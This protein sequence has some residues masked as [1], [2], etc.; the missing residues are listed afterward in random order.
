MVG[1]GHKP[2]VARRAVAEAVVAMAPETAARIGQGAVPNGDV[3]AVARIARIMGPK[4]RSELTPLGHP[5]PLDRGGVEVTRDRGD[6]RVRVRA[7]AETPARTGVEMEA[8][9]AAS[10]A[11]LAVY[12]MV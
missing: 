9:T 5:L 4:R 8:L 7:E 1:V 11:A 6:G 2:V 12:D 3:E 10:V